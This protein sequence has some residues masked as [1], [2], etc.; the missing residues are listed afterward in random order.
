MVEIGVVS[1]E[2]IEEAKMVP[3]SECLQL[4]LAEAIL[5]H[6]KRV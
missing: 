4:L 2:A 3:L 5:P 6:A 1:T